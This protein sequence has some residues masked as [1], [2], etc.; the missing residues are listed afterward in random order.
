MSLALDA[1]DT[2]LVSL[3]FLLL[4]VGEDYDVIYL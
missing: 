4:G 1:C 3:A 2:L